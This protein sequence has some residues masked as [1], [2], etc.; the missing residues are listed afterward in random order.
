[1]YDYSKHTVHNQPV[2]KH[3]MRM[4]HEI[5]CRTGGRYLS[6]PRLVG[7]F[8]RVDYAPGDSLMQAI[9]WQQCTTPIR[10]VSSDQWWRTAWRRINNIFK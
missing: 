6:N 1:M 3:K 5:L 9:L 10:E 8:F 2:P 7:E 4:F